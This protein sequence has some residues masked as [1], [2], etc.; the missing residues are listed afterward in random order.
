MLARQ[1]CVIVVPIAAMGCFGSNDNGP[2]SPEADAESVD[3]TTAPSPDASPS[4]AAPSDAPAVVDAPVDAP[5]DVALEAATEAGLP[6]L[7]VVVSNAAGPAPGILAILEDA[8]GAVVTAMPTDANGR[9][10]VSTIQAGSQVTLLFGTPTSANILT[11]EG[12]EPGDSIP[13][14]DP[15]ES[16]TYTATIQSL[17]ANPPPGTASYSAS[18]GSCSFGTFA[19]APGGSA[20]IVADPA[21]SGNGYPPCVNG[22]T[23]PVLVLANGG[24]DAGNAVLGYASQTDNTLV[25]TDGGQTSVSVGGSWATATSASQLNTINWPDAG[26]FYGGE[27]AIG[28]VAGGVLLPAANTDVFGTG[29]TQPL[30]STLYAAYGDSVQTEAYV[31]GLG[32]SITDIATRSSVDAG[33]IAIDM[34]RVLPL[35][36][37]ATVDGTTD[38]SRPSLTYGSDAGSLAGADGAVAVISWNGSNDGGPTVQSS[39]TIVAPATTATVKTP[40]LPVAAAGWGPFAGAFYG[41][42]VVAVIEATFL[43]GYAQLRANV[44]AVTPSTTLVQGYPHSALLPALL[45]EG[46]L[47]LT[48]YTTNGD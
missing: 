25:T 11:I 30:T 46:T 2:P 18:A 43:S 16:G 14:Y 42:P 20:D 47:R 35:I 45:S 38:P 19:A 7:D 36:D 17:P 13:I 15:S 24:P 28:Q 6:G 37:T 23:F 22:D 48:A 39:W 4:E 32:L 34:S 8:T 5:A 1:A 31:Y 29:P 40:A 21:G 33:S 27:L 26:V 12:L 44:S 41:T 3:N 10:T 9:F